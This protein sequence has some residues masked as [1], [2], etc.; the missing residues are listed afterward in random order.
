MEDDEMKTENLE[1]SA[2][3][4]DT[5]SE[6]GNGNIVAVKCMETYNER[7]VEALG[8]PVIRTTTGKDGIDFGNYP[9]YADYLNRMGR[10]DASGTNKIIMAGDKLYSSWR[11]HRLENRINFYCRRNSEWKSITEKVVAQIPHNMRIAHDELTEFF[12][13]FCL[14]KNRPMN[15]DDCGQPTDPLYP[16]LFSLLTTVAYKRTLSALKLDGKYVDSGERG[17]LVESMK[18][19]P[20]KFLLLPNTFQLSAD[21]PEIRHWV[22]DHE[23][24]ELQSQNDAAKLSIADRI[25]FNIA[26]Q[27]NEHATKLVELLLLML[28]FEPFVTLEQLATKYPAQMTKLEN[29]VADPTLKLGP[30]KN[31]SR[32]YFGKAM[33]NQDTRWLSWLHKLNPSIFKPSAPKTIDATYSA[34]YLAASAASAEESTSLINSFHKVPIKNVCFLLKAQLLP[35][36]NAHKFFTFLW[37]TSA[38]SFPRLCE[39]LFEIFLYLGNFYTPNTNYSPKTKE[40]QK[41]DEF[42]KVP[43]DLRSRPNVVWKAAYNTYL[44]YSKANNLEVPTTDFSKY[45]DALDAIFVKGAVERIE[46]LERKRMQAKKLNA[47]NTG[48]NDNGNSSKVCPAKES[49]RCKMLGELQKAITTGDVDWLRKNLDALQG[50]DYNIVPWLRKS[51]FVPVRQFF[52]EYYLKKKA[53]KIAKVAAE[54]AAEKAVKLA[55]LAKLAAHTAQLGLAPGENQPVPIAPDRDDEGSDYEDEDEDE[56]LFSDDEDDQDEDDDED[57]IRN[58]ELKTEVLHS[59]KRESLETIMQMDE[60]FPILRCP[61]FFQFTPLSKLLQNPDARVLDY[62]LKQDPAMICGRGESTFE[63]L[64]ARTFVYLMRRP[65]FIDECADQIF[66]RLF[67]RE[68]G[69]S[70]A[71]LVNYRMRNQTNKK[72]IFKLFLLLGNFSTFAQQDELWRQVYQIYLDFIDLV[73][74]TIRTRALGALMLQYF[75]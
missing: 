70:K 64:S 61:D 16:R 44:E 35:K 37:K 28:K 15:L 39:R 36:V 56:D 74:T 13:T 5:K 18:L 71:S 50:K 47:V 31:S 41:A 52:V 49:G 51:T 68:D 46:R 1:P 54:R 23:F 26:M 6:S 19:F 17:N 69:Y 75:V 59:L 29:E 65:E 40:E 67:V 53:D 58:D 9:E 30:Q 73:N 11:A 48:S 14:A 34:N 25:H 7:F 62:F 24:A 21:C 4:T 12:S 27:Q 43:T 33:V 66:M 57:E 20:T 8:N 55:K 2:A 10:P 38:S 42:E 45:K 63:K 32:H 72:F 60:K 3:A 22:L